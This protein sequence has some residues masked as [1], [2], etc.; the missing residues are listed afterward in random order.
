MFASDIS[1]VPLPTLP[2]YSLSYICKS[3]ENWG[4]KEKIDYVWL[5][6]EKR[7]GKDVVALLTDTADEF[8]MDFLVMGWYGGEANSR[9]TESSLGSFAEQALRAVRIRSLMRN[10]RAPQ[11][12]L[13]KEPLGPYKQTPLSA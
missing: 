5:Q 10:N 13:Q 2:L 8:S 4:I 3:T 11:S 6:K 7:D 9:G 1:V 12:P